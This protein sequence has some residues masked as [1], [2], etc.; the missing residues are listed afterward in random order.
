FY[1]ERGVGKKDPRLTRQVHDLVRRRQILEF[2]IEGQRSRSRQFLTPRRGMLKCLQ[3]TE[4]PCSI[5]PIA[6]TYDRI[7]EQKTFL[8]EMKGELKPP[9]KLR[10]LFHWLGRLIVGQVKLGRVH[11]SCGSPL[12]LYPS[13]DIQTLS[14]S[15]MSQ[16]QE[17]TATTTYHLEYFIQGN[18][19]EAFDSAWLKKAVMDR[20]GRVLESRLKVEKPASSIIERC[21]RYHWIH[22]FYEEA[23]LYFPNHPAIQHHITKNKFVASIGFTTIEKSDDP[24]LTNLLMHLF[25]PICDDYALLANWLGSVAEPLHLPVMEEI[26][27]ENPQA[28]LPNLEAALEDLLERQI[29]VSTQEGSYRWGPYAPDLEMYRHAVEWPWEE[30][31]NNDEK[32]S[33]DGRDR[34]FGTAS[35]GDSSKKIS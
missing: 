27:R 23:R 32:I 16:L 17:Q 19:V 3:S 24:K 1:I 12:P 25:K 31:L 28:H 22:L 4:Q 33:C 11:I 6:I 10:G 29:I 30:T 35:V 26:I 20:G 34:I 7:P 21:L 8:H 13:T 9:M 5:L 15:V 18:A 14:R 2:F